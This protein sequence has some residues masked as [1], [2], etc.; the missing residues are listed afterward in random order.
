MIWI[1]ILLLA[2]AIF[3]GIYCSMLYNTLYK[4]GIVKE[5]GRVSFGKLSTALTAAETEP[6][7]R[8]IDR[9]RRW[10]AFY[11]LAFFAAVIVGVICILIVVI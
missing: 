11:V 2:F 7:Y 9:C 5:G 8:K 10:Y 6:D 3:A 1:A 4:N